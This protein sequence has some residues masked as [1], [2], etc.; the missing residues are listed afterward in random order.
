MQYV[1]GA[2][3]PSPATNTQNAAIPFADIAGEFQKLHEFLAEWQRRAVAAETALQNQAAPPPLIDAS[4]NAQLLGALDARD[5]ALS[6]LASLRAM[7][8]DTTTVAHWRQIA[9]RAEAEAAEI[10]AAWKRKMGNSW[11]WKEEI[12]AAWKRKVGTSWKWKPARKRERVRR[13]AR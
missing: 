9:K 6:E 12:R 2:G 7:D 8:K 11:E 4:L 1:L 3:F 10:R 13:R 5:A